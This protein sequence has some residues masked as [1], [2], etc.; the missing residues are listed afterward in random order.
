MTNDDILVLAKA[1]FTAQQ[2]AALS[3]V[4]TQ[5]P[6]VQAQTAPTPVVP[7]TTPVVPAAPMQP[8]GAMPIVAAPSQQTPTGGTMQQTVSQ[9]PNSTDEIL[10]AIG[11]LTTTIQ[12]SMLQNTQQPQTPT[13]E[14]I[15]AEI[16]NPPTKDK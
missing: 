4:Q 7:P 5:P 3:Q 6:V 16:I 2:I 1:G 15:L 11:G 10:K 14:S 12:S 9:A 13:A 8:T